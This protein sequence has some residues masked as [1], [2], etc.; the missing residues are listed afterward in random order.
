MALL[1]VLIAIILFHMCLVP[2]LRRFPM[3]E[4]PISCGTFLL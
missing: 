1:V 3:E 2:F 4:N